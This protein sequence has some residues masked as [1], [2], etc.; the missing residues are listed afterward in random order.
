MRAPHSDT[1]SDKLY[2]DTTNGLIPYWLRSGD[3][4]DMASPEPIRHRVLS[5]ALAT[6]PRNSQEFQYL[7]F[8]EV[9]AETYRPAAELT[10]FIIAHD[11]EAAD[12][13]PA[14]T[15]TDQCVGIKIQSIQV[16]IT[17]VGVAAPGT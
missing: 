11:R 12:Q 1:H 10:G 4:K 7:V 9:E 8:I 15:C 16:N 17:K 13:F 2:F 14:K 5:L 3:Q 6:R